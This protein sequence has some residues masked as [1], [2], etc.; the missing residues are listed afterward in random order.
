MLKP[1]AFGQEQAQNIVTNNTV[2]IEGFGQTG[3]EPL[4]KRPQRV[5]SSIP[6]REVL[7]VS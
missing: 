4:E 5:T 6:L 7:S 1:I 2:V 3:S